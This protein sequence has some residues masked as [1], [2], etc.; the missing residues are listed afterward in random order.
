MQK[1]S[2]IKGITC[3]VI[4]LFILAC[5]FPTIGGSNVKLNDTSIFNEKQSKDNSIIEDIKRI[6]IPRGTPP[7]EE[8]NKTFGGIIRDYQF[9]GP[10]NDHL[11]LDAIR[12]RY[13]GIGYAFNS[14]FYPRLYRQR[15]VIFSYPNFK[16]IITPNFIIGIISGLPGE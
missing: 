9:T 7:D 3:A 11:E 2:L 16:G 6:G 13:F 5:V 10:Y 12:V 1:T 4:V 8:W 15:H 14:G